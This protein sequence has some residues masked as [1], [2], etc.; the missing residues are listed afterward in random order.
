[1]KKFIGKIGEKTPEAGL[2]V[3]R[4]YLDMND[5]GSICL[6]G[7]D[8]SALTKTILE[9]NS[10]TGRLYVYRYAD[11]YGLDCDYDGRINLALEED[12]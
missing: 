12:E 6:K 11:L 2:P 10:E 3:I 7:I 5:N 1:M 4:F 8:S 9:I